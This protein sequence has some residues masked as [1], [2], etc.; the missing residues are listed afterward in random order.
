[1]L[2]NIFR[3]TFLCFFLTS[4]LLA[5][6]E[7]DEKIKI[8][9]HTF[10]AIEARSIGPAVMGGRISA[11][12]AVN[13]NPRIIYVGAASGGIWKSISGGTTFK[14]IFDKYTQSIGAIAID[15]AHPD[16]VWVGTGETWVRNSVS[17]GTGLY[18]TTDGGDNWKL[19]GLDSTERISRILINPE[20][21]KIVY[22]AAMGHLW[23]AN[24]ERGVYKTT[25]GGKSWE[26]ILYVDENTGCADLAMDPQEPDILYAAMWQF[27]RYP[28]FFESGGRG[29]GLYRT[30]DGGTTWKKLKN[31]LPEEELGRIAI[32]VA[33]SRPSTI[34]AVIESNK[35]AAYRSDDLG[36]NWARL[37]SSNY[38]AMRPF[39][40]SLL[41]VDPHDHNRI[42]KPGY[43]L[44]VSSDGGKSFANR[45]GFH[46]DL[47]ALW[48]N[49]GN[50]FHL[51]LG[52]D[53]GIYVSF[54]RANTWMFLNN[55][56][57]SQFYHVSFDM[58]KPYNVYGGLQDNGS[59]Y[60]PSQNPGGITNADW[61]N[62]GFGDGFYVFVD[63]HDKDIIY[64][65]YQGGN[66]SRLHR[67]TGERK[68]IKPYP[69]EGESKYRFNWNTPIHVTEHALYI[70][71]QFLFR[72]TNKGESWQRISGDL[73]TNDPKKQRQE[74]SGGITVDNTTAEN[75][76]TI[77]T[78]C[79]SPLNNDVIWVGTD[80]GNV[81]ITQDGGKSWTNVVKNIPDLPA[82]TWCSCIEASHHEPGTAYATFDG[83]RSGDMNVYVY[84][85][86]DFGQN[87]K[88]I[89]TNDI[90]GYAHVIKE[91]LVKPDL[92]F[93]GT[94]FG[95]FITIDGGE[96]WAQFT[97][98]FPP[99]PVMDIAIHPREHDVILATHGRGIYIIDDITYLRKITKN[100]IASDVYMFDSPTSIIKP[101]VGI[102]RFSGSD[103]FVGSNPNEVAKIIYYMKKRHVFGD[104]K[105]EIYDAEGNLLKTLP[106][107]KRR[108]MNIVNWYMRQKPPKVAPAP[109]LAGGALFGPIVAE[110]TYT[111]KIIKGKDTYT[112]EIKVMYD[113]DSPHTAEDRALQQ[114]TVWKLYWMQERLAYIGDAVT[115]ARDKAKENA[116]KLKKGDSF[117]KTLNNFADKLD[118]LNQT[119]VATKTGAGI[120]GE[121]QLR[122][123]VVGLYASVSSYNG[124]PTESQLDRM[125]VLEKEIDKKN[126]EFEA[127]IGKELKSINK[128]LEGKKLEPIKI[129][130]KEEWDKKQEES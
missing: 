2:K 34:Y 125:N 20:D 43:I 28:D 25:D 96:Q 42:Y 4:L 90:E 78:I 47:H 70:G 69:K 91:D 24:E 51:I 29:S 104:L 86:T 57:V 22:V 48:I 46:P 121:Q 11:L 10:G 126:A 65:E 17:V 103:E 39:Y 99:V 94:E 123:K 107:G 63:P 13:S 15:Q 30:T 106:G 67:S 124:K 8:D 95:L 85:T 81:Q 116:K 44:N 71:A 55:I 26:K 14:P 56:P 38:I 68:D 93:V 16:T 73:T 52:T 114:T 102:Q 128:K 31:G 115:S 117:A 21:S 64:S 84:K 97:G 35:T 101:Q 27:R 75:H 60:G 100:V 111:A 72:S 80:D 53:G 49:P 1:M 7:Q 79:E 113:P 83:H 18:R 40:F 112:T 61:K 66:I 36:E 110:G 88:L 118:Q 50:P 9:S 3:V 77:Y 6:N 41:V 19:V 98:N 127:I 87:W 37:D 105:V 74:Q 122:E 12:D 130:T 92:L 119:L 33:P 76:C 59:W 5:A 89:K 62:C 23:D 108:G 120:T 45:G 54:D 82:N 109:T 58:E 32:A 129:M